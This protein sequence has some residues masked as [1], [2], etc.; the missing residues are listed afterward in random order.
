MKAVKKKIFPK[1]FVQPAN[2]PSAG[3]KNGNATGIL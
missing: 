2:A 1:K 3:E